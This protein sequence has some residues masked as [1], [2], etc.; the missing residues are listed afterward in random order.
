[1]VAIVAG[2]SLGLGLTSFATLGQRG[3]LGSASGGRSGELAYVNVATGNLILQ[4]GDDALADHG[5]M[6]T[7]VRTYNSLGLM[8]DDNG[9]NWSNGV[10][11]QQLKLNG[12]I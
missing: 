2:N 10:F 4:D 11:T 3:L 1:M 8:S 7:A 12:T 9:D 6:Q 5:R